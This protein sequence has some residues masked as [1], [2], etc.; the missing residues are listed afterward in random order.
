MAQTHGSRIVIYAALVGNFLIAVTK[1][2]ASMLTGSSAMLSESIHS[3][4]DTGN[5]GLLLW[6]IRRARRPADADHPFGYGMELYFWTFVVAILIFAVGAGVS[7]YEGIHKLQATE[8]IRNPIINYVVLGLAIVF[9]GVAWTIAFKEFNKQRGSRGFIR[10]VRR[11]KDP[12]VFTVLFEDSAAMLGL[13]FA[14]AGVACSVY[15][16][17]VVFDALASIGIGLILAVTAAVLAFESKGLL[18]GEAA[19]EAVIRDIRGIVNS[20]DDVLSINEALT[21][22]MGPRDIL[23]TLSLDFADG[24]SAGRVEDAISR[25]EKEIKS[26]HPEITRVFIEAQSVQGH[27]ASRASPDAPPDESP[28]PA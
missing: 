8:P 22:H 15:F 21:M 14:L 18:L 26:Q 6:G 13:L 28:Q 11:S 17:N 20:D 12:T 7:I 16:D 19:S 5:Q 25:M 9:E 10:A 23:L 4:V 1:F 2:A 24:I 27:H 3:L